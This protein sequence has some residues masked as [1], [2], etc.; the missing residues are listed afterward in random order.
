[1]SYHPSDRF[2]FDDFW[3]E[4]NPPP[5]DAELIRNTSTLKLH[6]Y[7]HEGR[8]SVDFHLEGSFGLLSEDDD[9]ESEA[10]GMEFARRLLA[11]F[12][13]GRPEEEGGCCE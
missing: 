5:A 3:R 11:E 4:R 6:V 1:M 2:D 8:L 12:A 13:K 7:R 9:P 10:K